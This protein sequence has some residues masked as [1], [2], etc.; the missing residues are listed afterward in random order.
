MTI[1][2]SALDS[3]LFAQRPE[4]S[5]VDVCLDLAERFAGTNKCPE[6][7]DRSIL[8]ATSCSSRPS[9]RGSGRGTRA[10]DIVR[11]KPAAWTL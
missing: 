11:A 2:G 8:G 10:P 4:H 5:S 3:D 1:A 7:D 9:R 6:T